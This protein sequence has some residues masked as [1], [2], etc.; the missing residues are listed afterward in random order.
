MTVE[1]RDET[2]FTNDLH[3]LQ[4]IADALRHK[5][6]GKDVREAI[7]QAVEKLYGIGPNTVISGSPAGAYATLSEL[8]SAYPNGQQG[9]FVVAETGKWYIWNPREK[10]WDE[11]GNFQSPMSQNEIED[12]R[13]WAD[14]TVSPKIGDAIRGQVNKIRLDENEEHNNLFKKIRLDE[15]KEHNNLYNDLYSRIEILP[16]ATYGKYEA[17]NIIDADGNTIENLGEDIY[18]FDFDKINGDYHE[19]KLLKQLSTPKF[20]YWGQLPVLELN[21]LPQKALDYGADKSVKVEKI[22]YYFLSKNLSGFLDSVKIQGNTSVNFPKKNYTLKF[23]APVVLHESWG[24]H[25]KYVIKSNFNDAS[26]IRNLLAAKTWGNIIKSR[27]PETL[28]NINLGDDILTDKDG[29]AITGSSD[30]VMAIGKNYGAIDGYPITLFINGNFH[31]IYNLCIPKDNW[32][33]DMSHSTEA[34]VSA[35]QDFAQSQAQFFKGTPDFNGDFEIEWAKNDDGWVKPS[36]IQAVNAVKADYDSDE[37]YYNNINEYIDIDS[38]ID[39]FIFCALFDNTDG[40]GKNYLLDTFDKKRWHFTAY[41]MDNV[42]G[43]F[44]TWNGTALSWRGYSGFDFYA[45]RHRM[46][47]VILKHMKDRLIKRYKTLRNNALRFSTLYDLTMDLYGSIPQYVF[48]A[49]FVRWPLEPTTS[50]RTA[51][52]IIF[53]LDKRL[54]FL[55]DEI[56]WL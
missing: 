28:E 43:V 26:Q 15:N 35:D 53:W 48:N 41:D 32:M 42:I 47:E 39:Y 3:T 19:Q 23:N 5:K 12:G 51:D 50:I 49:E 16:K 44:K 37:A 31:G 20:K 11:G 18:T 30:R 33:A 55:D 9:V 21:N 36:I 22:P 6:F 27:L 1:Y 34:I 40:V 52:Q 7:A 14:G 17:I 10:R 38:A 45:K 4:Q 56:K 8:Q 29:N 54:Q 24:A 46:F 13:K 25:T 2:P